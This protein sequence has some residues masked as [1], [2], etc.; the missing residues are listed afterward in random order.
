MAGLNA[1]VGN[2]YAPTANVLVGGVGRVYGSLFG[3]N[4]VAIVPQM[5]VH[6][7]RRSD[8]PSQPGWALGLSSIVLRPAIGVR[9]VF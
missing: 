6:F 7:I 9:A 2:L 3:K 8:D 4:I 1:F 5:R